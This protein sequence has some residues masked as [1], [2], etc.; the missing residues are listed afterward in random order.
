MSSPSAA[1][2]R[3]ELRQR[4][5]AALENLS[6]D[7]REVL[8]Q[9]YLEQMR[10]KEIAA[11]MGISEAAVNMRLMRALERMRKLLSIDLT[12]T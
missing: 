1:A 11:V 2:V 4:V 9:R 12:E 8:L 6:A 5:G 3:K 10:S 7:D